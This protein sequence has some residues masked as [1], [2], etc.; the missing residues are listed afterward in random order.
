MDGPAARRSADPDSK[1]RKRWLISLAIVSNGSDDDFSYAVEGV[2][3]D[4]LARPWTKLKPERGAVVD[5]EQDTGGQ[6]GWWF[7]LAGRGFRPL[8]TTPRNATFPAQGLS[9]YPT[10]AHTTQVVGVVG[11]H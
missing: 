5:E 4:S 3:M 6:P 9:L 2:A 1:D 11:H 8:P 7:L 10:L